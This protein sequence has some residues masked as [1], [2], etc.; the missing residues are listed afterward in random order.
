MPGLLRTMPYVPF[1]CLSALLHPLRVRS[2]TLV[3]VSVQPVGGWFP[4]ARVRGATMVVD[5]RM[6]I[7]DFRKEPFIDVPG[8]KVGLPE[9][10]LAALVII[11]ELK[12]QG[13][14]HLIVF[15]ITRC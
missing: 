12:F 15:V 11:I 3:N 5:V 4:E 8:R 10:S 2:H 13:L 7:Y 1:K 6:G 14:G 9:V